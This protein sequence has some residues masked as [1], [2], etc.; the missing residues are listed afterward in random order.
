MKTGER[1]YSIGE[2]ATIL[3]AEFHRK[4]DSPIRDRSARHYSDFSE[5]WRHAERAKAVRDLEL[6][7]SVVAMKELFFHSGWANYDTARPPTLRIAPPDHRISALA[8]D[9]DRMREMFFEEP[10][11]FDRVLETLHEA[12]REI[13]A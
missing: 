9:Y 6:L 12:E 10:P 11:P 13:N 3:H 1:G 4:Q 8:S 5:L 2:K 7:D